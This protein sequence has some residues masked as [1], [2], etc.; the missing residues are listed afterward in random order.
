MKNNTENVMRLKFQPVIIIFLIGLLLTALTACGTDNTNNQEVVLP[1]LQTSDPDISPTSSELCGNVLYPT[2][3][4]AAWVYTSTGGPSG[5]FNYTNSIT[6]TR[7]DGFTLTS[8]FIDLTR[9]QE[10]ACE[11]GGL[12]ALQLGGGSAAGIS[13]QG[14]TAELATSEVTGISIPQTV[15]PGMQWQYALKLQGTVAMPGDQQAQSNGGYTV[16]MKELGRET[17]TVPAGTFEAIK[18]QSNSNVDIMAVFE[19]IEVPVKFNGTTITWYAPGVGYVKSVE[20]GDF[21]GTA[22]SAT[23]ELQSYSI[24]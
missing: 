19:G 8:Q 23:T 24:P 15:T 5:S 7:A 14:M 18:I 16:D 2:T 17:V 1:I 22:Y 20:N 13:I 10:W 6:E 4:G 3:Q 12:K 11:L 9:T 21:G